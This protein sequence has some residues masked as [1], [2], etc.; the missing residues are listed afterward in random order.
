MVC[1]VLGLVLGEMAE[2]NL[3]ISL[4]IYGNLSFI[5]KK[6]ISLVLFIILVLVIAVPLIRKH[7]KKRTENK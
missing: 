6:P 3:G 4:I 2:Q 5:Y 1:L 7:L